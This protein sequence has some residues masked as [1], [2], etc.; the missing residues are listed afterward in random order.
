[1]EEELAI[2]PAKIET[3]KRKRGRP[4]K[5]P[6]EGNKATTTPTSKP[7]KRK[8]KD[9][10]AASTDADEIDID[11]ENLIE[12]SM[13][14]D[15]TANEYQESALSIKNPINLYG[16][17]RSTT[18]FDLRT[19][20]FHGF[21]EKYANLLKMVF[22]NNLDSSVL[23]INGKRVSPIVSSNELPDLKDIQ[24]VEIDY[25]SLPQMSGLVNW[26][27][28][29]S[30]SFETVGVNGMRA[31]PVNDKSLRKGVILNTGGVP[32]VSKWYPHQ[33]NGKRY[34]FVNVVSS[35][36]N[37]GE[38]K[39]DDPV[40]SLLNIYQCSFDDNSI[41]LSLWKSVKLN[42]YFKELHFTKTPNAG[43]LMG[44]LANGTVDIWNMNSKFFSSKSKYVKITPSMNIE[45]P[46]PLSNITCAAFI[47][48][49]SIL[50]GGTYG[51]IAKYTLP[52][53]TPDFIQATRLPTISSLT[54]KGPNGSILISSLDGNCYLLDPFKST[55]TP[56]TLIESG[57]TRDY[58]FNHRVLPLQ[59]NDSYLVCDWPIALK[60]ITERDP[61]GSQ[62][63]KIGGEGEVWSIGDE[64][65]AIS[66][67]VTIGLTNG[68]L[69]I[70]NVCN[71]FSNEDRKMDP[72]SIRLY[73][74]NKIGEKYSLDL[75]YNVDTCSDIS[76]EGNRKNLKSEEK[77]I[78]V[79]R[80]DGVCNL[81][82]GICDGVLMST[83]AN[84]IISVEQLLY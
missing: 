68:S 62:R 31:F 44:V 14:K 30:N 50:V 33:I 66:G 82:N 9:S 22:N 2:G 73:Q 76:N 34:L 26:G 53:V 80:E 49:L 6:L 13:A 42:S 28:N 11:V 60:V 67:L 75:S 63:A 25:K 1:M 56:P 19:L 5:A 15:V 61:N 27:F 21:N 36:D 3:P 20:H 55:L 10:K 57:S 52:K 58:I 7:S 43:L 48:N 74:M 41:P 8:K 12:A 54:S 59:V 45:L 79:P 24:M 47:D 64:V 39:F 46:E 40:G 37:L 83:W 29:D 72:I 32:I 23:P 77:D 18:N 69:K 70:I 35:M 81:S 38:G 4:R 16:T 65:N 84:G 71:Y 17:S 51:L 78:R